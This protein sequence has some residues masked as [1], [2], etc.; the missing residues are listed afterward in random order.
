VQPSELVEAFVEQARKADAP[1]QGIKIQEYEA[2]K[3]I[4]ALSPEEQVQVVL[5]AVEEQ[6]MNA[7][8]RFLSQRERYYLC[9]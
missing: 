6:V 5:E 1:W 7:N 3:R 4:A 2:G 8:R 9:R